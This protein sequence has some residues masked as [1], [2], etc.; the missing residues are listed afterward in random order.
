MKDQTSVY[1]TQCFS[2]DMGKVVLSNMLIE[3]GFFKHTKTLEE[4]AVEN[5]MKTVL[6]KCGVY[7]DNRAMEHVNNFMN[8]R[9][10]Y[11]KEES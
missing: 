6:C 1:Y 5:F 2:T 7:D 4:Q 8:M 11:G 9:V 3:A 10:D